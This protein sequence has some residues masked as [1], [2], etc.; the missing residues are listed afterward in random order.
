MRH[1]LPA[2]FAA[3]TIL[4][5]QATAKPFTEMFPG[6]RPDFGPQA[7]EA[8]KQIDY[9]QGSVTL[10]NGLA[11]LDVGPDFYFLNPTDARFVLED[12]WGNPPDETTLGM[13]FPAK[14]TPLDD[15]N[16]GIEIYFDNSGYVSDEDANDYDYDELL[17]QM[18]A[19]T[20][21]ANARRRAAN[22][23]EIELIGWA[24]EPRYDATNR[25]L[26]WAKELSFEGDEVNTLNYNIRALGRRGVLNLNFIAGISALPEVE[27]AVPS[28]LTMV[29]FTEGN[30]Y[31]DFNP[32]TDAMAAVGI[33]GLIAGGVLAK[34]TGL[35]V[36]AVLF[37]K[38]G[39]FLLLLPLVWLKNLFTGRRNS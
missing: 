18:Q 36:L 16:W 34:K 27:T 39:G 7:I 33:G 32:S 25:Q 19:D 5:G 35:L 28:V 14:A 31:T 21:A 20:R 6:G 30:R 4:A 10:G 2:A 3:L 11:K 23:P 15:G 22:Y 38:K 24:A 37:L 26:Y 29:S 17:K 1:F 9:Q 13:I 8:L 12:L